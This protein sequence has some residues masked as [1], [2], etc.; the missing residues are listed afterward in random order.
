[1]TLPVAASHI[2]QQRVVDEARA[3]DFPAIKKISEQTRLRWVTFL[4]GTA[5]QYIKLFASKGTP[6]ATAFGAMYLGSWLLFEGLI[7]AAANDSNAFQNPPA[8]QGFSHS[9]IGTIWALAASV[10]NSLVYMAPSGFVQPV[11]SLVFSLY[12]HTH[13]ADDDNITPIPPPF[14]MAWIVWGIL[15]ISSC[16]WSEILWLQRS[17]WKTL[18]VSVT[19]LCFFG[20]I[21]A[22]VF[23][24]ARTFIEDDRVAR[25]AIFTSLGG[26]GLLIAAV[27]WGTGRQLWGVRSLEI[28]RLTTFL[29]LPVVYYCCLYDATGTHQP[30]WLQWLG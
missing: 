11:F 2:L 29:Y 16:L 3:A 24:D 1:M 17:L 6:L 14:I 19:L 25:T 30:E 13:D 18:L 9:R 8:T 21:V 12:S 23:F 27:S 22:P 28:M 10:C 7:V 5:P 20:Y 4:L 26:I 15:G